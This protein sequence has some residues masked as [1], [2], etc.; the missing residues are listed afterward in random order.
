MFV[1]DLRNAMRCT[2]KKLKGFAVTLAAVLAIVGCV[3]ALRGKAGP[4]LAFFGAAL[5]LI[6]TGFAAPAVLTP[7]Y[8]VWMAVGSILGWVMTRVVLIVLFAGVI[9]PTGLLMRAFGKG[10]LTVRPDP[11]AASYWKEKPVPEG[12]PHRYE[13]QY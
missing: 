9:T 11:A 2:E 13:N 3:I 4:S 1:E 7:V 6:A 5:A 12:G 10:T 8:K